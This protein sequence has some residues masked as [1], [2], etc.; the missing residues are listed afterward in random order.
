MASEVLKL[1]TAGASANLRERREALGLSVTE[2]GH[3]LPI[4]EDWYHDLEHDDEEIFSN[5]SLITLSLILRLIGI[6]WGDLFSSEDKWPVEY[7][8]FEELKQQVETWKSKGG[9]STDELSE[10]VGYDLHDF[11]SDA[12]SARDWNL[13]C[14][15]KLCQ[16]VGVDWREYLSG[17]N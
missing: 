11:V 14:L 15:L 12:S 3:Q 6:S 10:L 7:Q 4:G 8:S 2:M 16:I 5:V 17:L 13:E 9:R 1:V